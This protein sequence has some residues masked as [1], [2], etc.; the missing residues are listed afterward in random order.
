MVTQNTAKEKN[1]GVSR[2]VAKMDFVTS[3]LNQ[4]RLIPRQFGRKKTRVFIYKKMFN[5]YTQQTSAKE[6]QNC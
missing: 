4:C 3:T 5:L 2:E 6:T 1:Q